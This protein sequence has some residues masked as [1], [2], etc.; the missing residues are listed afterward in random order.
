M[1][2]RAKNLIF[3]GIFVASLALVFLVLVLTQPK[4]DKDDGSSAGTSQTIP[5]MARERDDIVSMKITNSHGEYTI[6]QN[7]K[8]FFINELEGLKQNSTTMGAAGN[9]ITKINAQ[10]LAE[11]NASDLAKYGLEDGKSEASCTVTLKDGTSYTVLYGI[12]A[13]DGSSVYVRL[14]DS[15]DVYVVLGNSSRYFYNAKE[16]FISVI[17]KEEITSESTAPTIDLLTI[18]RKDLDYDIVFEDDTKNYAIDEVSMA[19]SQVMI[20]P[21]YAYLDITNSNDIIYGIWGLTASEAIKPFPTEADFEEYGLDDPF[22]TVTLSAEL[23]TYK[24]RIGNVASYVYDE[25]GNP[26]NEPAYYYGYFD[27]IDCI[28]TFAASEVKW[29]SFM[30]VDVLSSMMTSNYIYALDYMDIQLH[31]GE[32]ASYYFDITGNVDDAS[33]SATLNDKQV[34]VPSFK[35]LYQFILKCPI[36]ALCL[37]DPAEDAKL[38]AHIEFARAKGGGDTLD[39]YDDG[40]NRVVIKLNGVT[41]FSQ[42]KS[43]L[44][45]LTSNLKLFADGAAGD[46]LQMIW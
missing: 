10:A 27:G 8:G 29:A 1:K 18:E 7:A 32:E 11:E 14:S 6:T 46:D 42:P 4:T 41:S 24:L 45:V 33:L 2:S 22:C 26:T 19:S 25:Q 31:N 34:D 40:S 20:S 39:F 15:K 28:Y 37:E 5:V 12:N 36:D 23:Q 21:V 43:Y 3:I 9:C 35:I 44:D 30:P 13:P 38:L 16:S 17:V